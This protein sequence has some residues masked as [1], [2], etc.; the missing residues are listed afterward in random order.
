LNVPVLALID[1]YDIRSCRWTTNTSP[2]SSMAPA[3]EGD[4][5]G[6]LR[7]DHGFAEHDSLKDTVAHEFVGPV[8][9]PGAAGDPAV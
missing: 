2:P 6:L 4:V 8:R 3:E 5:A 9:R 1:E 7:L